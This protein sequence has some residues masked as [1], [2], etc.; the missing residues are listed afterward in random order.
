MTCIHDRAARRVARR[1]AA[2]LSTPPRTQERFTRAL[3][4][5]EAARLLWRLERR[6][7]AR[8]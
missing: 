4:L 6:M 2:Y 7:G 5:A 1:Q 8:P 3:L